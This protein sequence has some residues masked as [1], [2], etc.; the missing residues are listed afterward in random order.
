MYAS[1][2]RYY[3]TPLIGVLF[4]FPSRYLFAIGRRV[5][6]SLGRWSSQ[7]P[8]GFLVSRGTRELSPA[9]PVHFAYGAI[10]LYGGPFQV[11]SAIK[12]KTMLESYNPPHLTAFDRLPKHDSNTMRYGV[13]AIPV[14][15]AATKGISFDFFSLVTKMFQ[16]AKYPLPS[17]CIQLGVTPYNRGWVYPFGNLRVKVC[18]TTRRSLSQFSTSF[19]GTKCQGIHYTLFVQLDHRF[20]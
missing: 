13:W 9:R 4:T 8:T 11:P 16:F 1:G 12:L 5:V 17:L 2:F 14:S 7:I 15:L 19:I 10:T 6:L 3:F 18:I 20:I